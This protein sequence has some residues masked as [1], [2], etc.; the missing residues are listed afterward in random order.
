MLTA[1]RP[2]PRA[3]TSA[4]NAAFTGRHR[5]RDL[6]LRR[7]HTPPLAVR[8]CATRAP[9]ASSAAASCDRTSAGRCGSRPARRSRAGRG[10][11]APHFF[12]QHECLPCRISSAATCSSSQPPGFKTRAISTGWPIAR[13]HPASVW[14]TSN[15]VTRSNVPL[16]NGMSPMLACATRWPC[17][18]AAQRDAGA[19]E[20]EA[21]AAAI[22]PSMRRF[23]PVPQPQSRMRGPLARRTE[24]AQQAVHVLTEAAKPEVGL[25]RSIRQLQQSIGKQSGVIGM[26]PYAH[27]C[28]CADSPRR[29]S[30]S[31]PRSSSRASSPILTSSS[32]APPGASTR[33]TAAG[34]SGWCRGWRTR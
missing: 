15:D 4:V 18:C 19:G 21:T 9:A 10:R 32:S 31:S 6:P 5:H 1:R 30:S 29:R 16:R 2:S 14:K 11:V 26:L 22:A 8:R 24:R 20:I 27:T 3:D 33:T 7:P 13:P 23:D 34:A 28:A 25:L 12:R 17:G